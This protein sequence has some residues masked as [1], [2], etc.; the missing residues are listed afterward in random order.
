MGAVPKGCVRFPCCRRG[1][2][3]RCLLRVRP[4]RTGLVLGRLEDEKF[5][6]Y[7]V[8][9]FDRL[10]RDCRFLDLVERPALLT[11]QTP[12]IVQPGARPQPDAVV[13]GGGWV[14]VRI[15]NP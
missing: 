7:S 3:V 11:S 9:D 8:S 14:S 1:Y 5:G 6:G 4:P 12:W 13:T 15:A 10:V 2:R